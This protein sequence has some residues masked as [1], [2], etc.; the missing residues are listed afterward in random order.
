LYHPE[1]YNSLECCFNLDRLFEGDPDFDHKAL[2]QR[3]Y[4]KVDKYL[5]DKDRETGQKLHVFMVKQLH[6]KYDMIMDWQYK[7]KLG[8]EPVAPL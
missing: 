5:P 3:L 7:V 8:K 6:T 2:V 1:N 4:V